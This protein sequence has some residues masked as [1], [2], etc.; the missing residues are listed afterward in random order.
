MVTKSAPFVKLIV[1]TPFFVATPAIFRPVDVSAKM[2]SPTLID[3]SVIVMVSGGLAV[4]DVPFG[5][6]HETA[7]EIR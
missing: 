2:A 1:T 6:T 7:K 4:G 3:E 5:A